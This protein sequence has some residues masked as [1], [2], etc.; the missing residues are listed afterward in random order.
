MTQ[1]GHM[2]YAETGLWSSDPQDSLRVC[3]VAAYPSLLREST[4]GVVQVV[5][6]SHIQHTFVAARLYTIAWYGI[7]ATKTFLEVA[8]L[9]LS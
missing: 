4:H 8:F 2:T 1:L 3:F 9:C 5:S 7:V 6:R